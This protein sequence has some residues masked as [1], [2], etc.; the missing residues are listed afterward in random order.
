MELPAW[1]RQSGRYLS[2]PWYLD[3]SPLFRAEA[4]AAPVPAFARHG[5]RVSSLPLE[6]A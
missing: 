2:V 4:D 3:P 5:V 6:R 1:A